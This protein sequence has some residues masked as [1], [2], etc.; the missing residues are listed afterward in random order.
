MNGCQEHAIGFTPNLHP[1][2]INSS[3]KDNIQ[4]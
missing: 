3:G 2:W 4:I 1:L